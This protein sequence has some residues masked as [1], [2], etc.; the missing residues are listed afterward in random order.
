MTTLPTE[1]DRPRGQ[2]EPEFPPWD[3]PVMYFDDISAIAL[4]METAKFYLIREVS[5]IQDDLDVYN[6]QV[7]AQVVTARSTIAKTFVRFGSLV[8][9]WIDEGEVFGGE[10]DAIVRETLGIEP[11]RK[12]EPTKPK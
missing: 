10:L 5:A 1:D 7:I 12:S 2:G 8:R 3:I 11:Q 9:R 4:T 6:G